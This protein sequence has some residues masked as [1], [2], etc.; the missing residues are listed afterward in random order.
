[1]QFTILHNPRCSKSRKTLEILRSHGVEPGIVRYLDTPPSADELVAIA[2]RLGQPLADLLRRGETVFK[3]ATDLPPL[4]DTA[5]L[6]AWMSA[7]P[8]TLERP[9]VLRDDGAARVGRP[10]SLF[11]S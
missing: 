2:E 11:W 5:A 1:M 8:I 6:A 9:I 3:R 10:P 4:D 7:N